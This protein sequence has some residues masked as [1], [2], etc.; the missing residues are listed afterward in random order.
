MIAVIFCGGYGTRLRSLN[1]KVPKP[2]V[3]VK[4]KEI[5]WRICEIYL[6]NNIDKIILLTGYKHKFFLEN[7]KLYSNKKIQILNTGIGTETGERL[8]KAKKFINGDNFFLTYGDSLAEVD[9]K[10]TFKSHISSKKIVSLTIFK[11]FFKY[12]FL[13]RKNK[14]VYKFNEKKFFNLNSGFYVVS[15]KIFR[16][17]KKK[18]SFEKHLLP[19]LAKKKQINISAETKNWHPLDD[20]YDFEK[21]KGYLTK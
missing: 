14:N 11:Y 17:L 4:G 16:Y 10:K 1:S 13:E 5:V 15:K 6:K 9:L 7:K 12:G 2:L 3:K 19:F 20:K 21:M 18:Q 8:L